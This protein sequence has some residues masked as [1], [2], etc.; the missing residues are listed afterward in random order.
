M[1]FFGLLT[2]LLVGSA[3]ACVDE[4]SDVHWVDGAGTSG[5]IFNDQN[6][7]NRNHFYYTKI[8]Q[9]SQI[10][11][12]GQGS[13]FYQDD[14]IRIMESTSVEIQSNVVFRC[15][16]M[17][18]ID[19]NNVWEFQDNSQWTV[20]FLVSFGRNGQ[21][22]FEEYASVQSDNTQ[23]WFKPGILAGDNVNLILRYRSTL[24][25]GSGGLLLDS[26]TVFT[27]GA[28]GTLSIQGRSTVKTIFM[29]SVAV[30]VEIDPGVCDK[31]FR[32]GND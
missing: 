32:Q 5:D 25:L 3:T 7:Y 20:E 19:T 23:E 10:C 11:F 16:A 27:I 18:F 30:T 14:E 13:S 24:D 8:D 17:L 9:T 31:R 28:G 2:L 15:D 29:G 12:T 26:S 4:I 21:V 22:T 1:I 6:M